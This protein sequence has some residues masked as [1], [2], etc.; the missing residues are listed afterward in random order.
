MEDLDALDLLA[1]KTRGGELLPW[2]TE[3]E[4]FTP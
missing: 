2:R 3:V 4:D 1:F